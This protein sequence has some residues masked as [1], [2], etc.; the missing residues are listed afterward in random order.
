M[1][2]NLLQ[3]RTLDPKFELNWMICSSLIVGNILLVSPFSTEMK[4]IMHN[5]EEKY[6]DEM[7]K[8]R[9]ID[10]LK[11]CIARRIGKFIQQSAFVEFP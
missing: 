1:V 7:M 9:S 4:E 3:S 8:L 5:R 10:A 11:S 6:S 2:T